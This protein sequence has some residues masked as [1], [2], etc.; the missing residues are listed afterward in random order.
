MER[1]EA[2]YAGPRAAGGRL[3]VAGSP[4]SG[5]IIAPGTNPSAVNAAATC[6]TRQ[7]LA[8][9]AP[10]AGGAGLIRDLKPLP[11]HAA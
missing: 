9:S 7:T 1:Q 2:Q 5:A 3:D 4:A 6:S 11:E 8:P 10:I